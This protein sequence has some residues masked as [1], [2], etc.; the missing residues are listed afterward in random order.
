MSTKVFNT[1]LQLK[2]APYSEWSAE[3]NQFKLLAGEI[4]IVNVPAETGAVVSEPSILFKVGDGEKTFNQLPWASG[5]AA[6]VYGWA[7]AENKPEYAAT[8]ISLGDTTV[9]ANIADI[10]AKL[11]VLTG[12]ESGNGNSISDMIQNGINAFAA[13]LGTAAYAATTDFDA[14]GTGAAE[15]AKVLGTDA[16]AAGT[17]TVHGALKSAAAADANANSRV[18][19]SDFNSFKTTNTAAIE[20]AAKAGTD[21]ADV[22]DGKL[23]EYKTSNDAALAGVKAT[24]EAAY[25]LPEGGIEADLSDAV[26]A[27]LAKADS[28]LQTHQDISHLATKETVN[29]IDGRVGT[30]EADYLKAADKT[31]LEGKITTAETNAKAYA[32]EIK[33]DLLGESE[34]LEGTYDTL[35]EIAGWINTHEGETVVELTTAISD[36]ETARKAADEGFETRVS[37]L[38]GKVDV[39]KVSDAIA[40]GV[41]GEATLREAADTALSNRIKVYE[42]NKDTYALK[43]EVEAAE[44]RAAADATSKANTAEANAKGYT[45]AEIDKVEAEVAKKANIDDLHTVATSGKIEDLDQEVEYIIFNCGTA[46]TLVSEPVIE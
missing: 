21:A 16:D 30:I 42:D 2:Y 15:A 9:A 25:V 46:T 23:T 22:V 39:E 34:T 14:A 4:A 7:K 18:L 3:S 28:A 31:E 29:G 35:K 6:D 33:A 8:E 19:T 43:T 45:D 12:E 20:A 37:A 36:E 40:A 32:D 1:R 44:G 17:A 5:L 38:E 24:A 13:T 27:S 41:A 26:K 10:W 11:E